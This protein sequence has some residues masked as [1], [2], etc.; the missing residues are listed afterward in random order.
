MSAPNIIG[1][2]QGLAGSV[3]MSPNTLATTGELDATEFDKVLILI[4]TAALAGAETV[5]I[6]AKN[7][8]TP[9]IGGGPAGTTVVYDATGAA[10]SLKL[11]AQSIMLEGGFWYVFS[12]SA[13]VGTVGVCFQGKRSQGA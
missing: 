2:V 7:V 4:S 11:A 9:A 12:K 3:G 5:S 10:A 1:L 8:D 6:Y 13:T